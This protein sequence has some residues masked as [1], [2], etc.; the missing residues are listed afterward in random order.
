M[1]VS[2]ERWAH[3]RAASA[4]RGVACARSANCARGACGGGAAAA[5]VNATR[6]EPSL[7]RASCSAGRKP[8]RSRSPPSAAAES[9]TWTPRG[10]ENCADAVSAGAR[11]AQSRPS[12]RRLH[13]LRLQRHRL[14][15]QLRHLRR[16]RRRRRR[17][18]R[19]RLRRTLGGACGRRRIGLRRLLGGRRRLAGRRR[20]GRRLARRRLARALG[21]HARPGCNRRRRRTT[22]A[23]GR[24]ARRVLLAR[25]WRPARCGRPPPA[26]PPTSTPRSARAS[27]QSSASAA[28]TLSA[29]AAVPPRWSPPI[30]GCPR[31][32]GCR[33][34][35]RPATRCAAGSN[36]ASCAARQIRASSRRR[37]R[38]RGGRRP[39]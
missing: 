11:G 13:R 5:H 25:Q 18:R 14:R 36:R 3:A 22:S 16:R 7:W 27:S 37:A 29:A 26:P 23:R 17:I 31:G 1:A 39:G 38:V 32:A 10:D 28:R 33:C 19:C 9:V 21:R 15:L 20:L 4:R 34:L 12:S 8:S 6:A 35:Q 30:R 24:F 2:D